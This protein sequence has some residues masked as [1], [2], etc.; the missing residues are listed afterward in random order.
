[1]RLLP[2]RQMRVQGGDEEQQG[3]DPRRRQSRDASSP[4][5]ARSGATRNC[6]TPPVPR[7]ARP[8][9]PPAVGEPTS[10]VTS[11]SPAQSQTFA[12][13]PDAARA[14]PRRSDT[15]RP[16]APSP[17][18]RC[19]SSA[20]PQSPNSP[21]GPGAS[22][23]RRAACPRPAARRCP[24]SAQTRD[25][26]CPAAARPTISAASAAQPQREG[27]NGNADEQGQDHNAREAAPAQREQAPVGA[28]SRRRQHP[29]AEQHRQVRQDLHALP[30][31][32]GP[33][34]QSRRLSRSRP[35]QADTPRRCRKAV[36]ETPPVRRRNS[37]RPSA[38]SPCSSPAR[39][40]AWRANKS[41]PARRPSPTPRPGKAAPRAHTPHRPRTAKP[42]SAAHPPAAPAVRRSR[43]SAAATS[44]PASQMSTSVSARI[45]GR[46]A[47]HAPA[48]RR[49][50]PGQRPTHRFDTDPVTLQS[51]RQVAEVNVILASRVL[52]Q[53]ARPLRH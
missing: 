21:A 29:K 9:S 46:G 4:I 10:A 15:P 16:A 2:R 49:D 22:A 42:R 39:P 12:A 26:S 35:R 5:A 38:Q 13:P 37:P 52:M 40:G 33:R 27:H 8:P 51:I 20:P 34:C 1:M 44:L 11:A 50:G 41:T 30:L 31:P 6:R 18:C 45:G 28:S 7:S 47:N 17:R 3:H 53:Q 48:V 43:R 19:R 25:A 23:G 24:P 36:P 32:H 14:S